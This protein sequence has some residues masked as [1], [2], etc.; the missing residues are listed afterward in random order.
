MGTVHL[1][2]VLGALTALVAAGIAMIPS[3]RVEPEDQTAPA[4]GLATASTLSNAE[5]AAQ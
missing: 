4:D 3:K 1:V 2:T 5:G